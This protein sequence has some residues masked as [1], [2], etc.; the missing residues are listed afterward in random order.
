MSERMK[1]GERG[2]ADKDEGR[3]NRMKD[4][5]EEHKDDMEIYST[6]KHM[7]LL[8]VVVCCSFRSKGAHHSTW[9][10]CA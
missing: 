10:I 4:K 8:I 7:L 9:N 5:K 2:R 3:D 6:R 1:E